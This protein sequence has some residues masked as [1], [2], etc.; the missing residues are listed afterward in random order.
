MNVL[1]VAR[2]SFFVT[3]V[4]LIAVVVGCDPVTMP[5]EMPGPPGCGKRDPSVSGP[6]TM[7]VAQNTT[8]R[9]QGM[10]GVIEDNEHGGKSW[11]YVR[12]AGSVFGETETAE[13]FIFSAQGLLVAQKTEMR[14][15]VGR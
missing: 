10:P 6:S 7:S 12:Q 9:N 14:K 5:H 11:I 13:I 2:A 3:L 8:L 4:A 1:A 15:N